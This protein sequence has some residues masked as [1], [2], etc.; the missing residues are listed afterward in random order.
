[1]TFFYYIPFF[2]NFNL[3]LHFLRL[4]TGTSDD[5]SQRL[6][7]DVIVLLIL[8]YMMFGNVTVEAA[9]L[10]KLKCDMESENATSM[11]KDYV[12]LCRKVASRQLYFLQVYNKKIIYL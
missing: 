5:M 2:S 4:N 8:H 1:M 7:D 10:L 3:I 11:I 9:N 12:F 6:F